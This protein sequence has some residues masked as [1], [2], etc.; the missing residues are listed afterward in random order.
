MI[1][2]KKIKVF[3]IITIVTCLGLGYL[4]GVFLQPRV[5]NH[6]MYRSV[7]NMQDIEIISDSLCDFTTGQRINL[8]DTLAKK[9]RNL[10]VFWSPTC[11]FSKE[12]F[13]HQ[14]NEQVVGI[15]CFPLASDLEYLKFY[16]DNHDIKLPQLM[17]QT[18]ETFVPVEVSSIMATPTFVVVDNTGKNLAQYVGIKEID[19]MITFLYQGI[20]QYTISN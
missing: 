9:G 16:V 13:L 12:F 6:R 14:L 2:N 3:I 1:V 4:L 17:V 7:L 5:V 15:Y 11:S 19:D 18:S 20:Q 8:M 10:L